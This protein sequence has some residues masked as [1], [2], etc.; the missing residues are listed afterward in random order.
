VIIGEA[1]AVG[2]AEADF[3]SQ[4]TLAH[5]KQ[6]MF[7]MIRRDKNHPSV[8]MWSVANEPASN[9]AR[10]T[11][12]YNDDMN[13]IDIIQL[14]FLTLKKLQITLAPLIQQKDH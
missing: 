9:L 10:N 4:A 13:V 11:I 2:L 1:P 14:L 6:V 7:E 12:V 5:H 8:V 3:F